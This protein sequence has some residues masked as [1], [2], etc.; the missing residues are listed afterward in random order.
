MTGIELQERHVPRRI[1]HLGTWETRGWRLKVYGIAYG[2]ERPPPELVAAAK[3][4][5]ATTL[6]ADPSGDGRY[7]VGFL[8][9]HGARGG[10]Y[11]FL[12]WWS[13][14]NELHHHPFLGPSP[15]GL[16]PAGSGE[17]IACIWD[18]EVVDFERRAW[19]DTVLCNPAGPDLEQYLE[20][21]LNCAL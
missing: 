10:S 8:G 6:P 20:R 2:A 3:R 18:L 11:V 15:A 1:A 19:I 12:D 13:H 7:G 5:A 4:L 17:S 9:A 16:R 21:R 14:E